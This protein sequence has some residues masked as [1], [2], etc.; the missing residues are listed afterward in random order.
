MKKIIT[1]LMI[2]GLSVSVANAA[3][4][5]N[6]FMDIYKNQNIDAAVENAVEEGVAPDAIVENS[7]KIQTVNPQNLVKALYC[8]GV[9]G[10]DV[11]NAAKKNDV[12]ELIVAAGFKKSKDEC[13]DIVADTQAYTPGGRQGRGF[14]G[15]NR[16]QRGNPYSSPNS[17]QPQ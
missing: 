14:G 15:A 11:Y 6:K 4:W 1:A 5:L 2:F 7:L 9:S 17:F 13:S 16:G 10:E 12:S 3:N 8:A